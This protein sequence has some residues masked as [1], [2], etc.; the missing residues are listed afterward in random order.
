MSE[1]LLRS[2]RQHQRHLPR[3]RHRHPR[4][5]PASLSRVLIPLNHPCN[6][7]H[8][9]RDMCEVRGI[10]AVGE[11]GLENLHHY[12]GRQECL[13]HKGE[14]DGKE[15]LAHWGEGNWG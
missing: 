15:C 14:T 11:C 6:P 4:N 9:V 5:L 7:R 2:L 12:G 1:V 13:A 8:T 10:V 3:M